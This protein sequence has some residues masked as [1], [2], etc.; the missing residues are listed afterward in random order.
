MKPLSENEYRE[1]IKNTFKNGYDLGVK[2]AQ[3]RAQVETDKLTKQNKIMRDA[4]E[5]Y[6]NDIHWNE[7]DA[8]FSDRIDI[9]DCCKTNLPIGF[10]GGKRAR[11]ALK[12]AGEV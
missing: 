2:A 11:K 12:Q 1:I 6:G 8:G 7:I 9:S 3:E 10:V 5:F 4:L